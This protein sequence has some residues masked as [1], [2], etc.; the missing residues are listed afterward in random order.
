MMTVGVIMHNVTIKGERDDS[1]LD[2]ECAVHG[3]LVE[4]APGIII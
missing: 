2:Q 4:P 3:K 1:V